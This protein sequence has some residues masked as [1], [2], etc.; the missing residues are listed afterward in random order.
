MIEQTIPAD[1]LHDADC[2]IW[3]IPATSGVDR[4]FAAGYRDEATAQ[5]LSQVTPLYAALSRVLAQLSGLMLSSLTTRRG[6][7]ALDLDHAIYATATE[8]LREAGERLRALRVPQAAVRHHAAMG[9][10]AEH[11]Q[12]VARDMQKLTASLGALRAA[13][14]RDI[15][16]QLHVA[17]RLLIATAEPDARIT[18]VDFSNACCSCGAAHAPRHAKT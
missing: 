16:R 11:L 6:G 3:D 4:I 14:Q 13:G 5:Y 17:Q 2:G 8:Q 7:G 18:P 12:A 9:D 10:C 15:I 1:T